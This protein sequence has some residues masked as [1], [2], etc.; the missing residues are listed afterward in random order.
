M[1]WR[2]YSRKSLFFNLYFLATVILYSQN[3]STKSFRTCHLMNTCMDSHYSSNPTTHRLQLKV[4]NSK[5][6]CVPAPTNPSR[7]S[8][9]WR[10]KTLPLISSDKYFAQHWWQIRKGKAIFFFGGWEQSISEHYKQTGPS[11][12]LTWH[13][14]GD[15]GYR[16]RRWCFFAWLGGGPQGHHQGTPR[17][18]SDGS[19]CQSWAGWWRLYLLLPH[20]G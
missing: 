5:L 6:I 17:W 10:K 7:N 3:S 12:E 16:G 2:T 9:F 20:I 18:R 13:R 14:A 11:G 19:L 15:G 8:Y 1:N 4:Q